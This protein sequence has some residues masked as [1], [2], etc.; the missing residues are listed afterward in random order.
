M[1]NNN[2]IYL[3]K[4]NKVNIINII[5]KNIYFI[6]ILLLISGITE[7]PTQCFYHSGCHP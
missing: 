1:I 4:S 7:D 5:I 2:V 6:I 3:I